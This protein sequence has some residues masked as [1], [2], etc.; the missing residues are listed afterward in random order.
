MGLMLLVV[1]HHMIF[2][3]ISPSAAKNQTRLA[4]QLRCGLEFPATAATNKHSFRRLKA[5]NSEESNFLHVTSH[6]NVLETTELKLKN[7]GCS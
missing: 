2:K 6:D 4:A 5:G 3:Q 7:L 1:S